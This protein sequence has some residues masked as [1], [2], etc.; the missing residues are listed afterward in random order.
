MKRRDFIAKGTAGAVGAGLAGCSSINVKRELSPHSFDKKVPKPSGT[1]PMGEIGTTGIKVS[2]FGFGSHMRKDIVPFEKDREWM[3]REAYDLGVRLFDV[4]DHE[5]ETYQYEPMGRHL[6]PFINDVAI[7]I[8]ILP[9]EGRTLE[10]EFERDLRLFGRDH[11][12]MVR[13]HSYN[14]NADNWYQ[15][16]HLFKWKEQGKIRAV[17]IPIHRIE[18]VEEPLATYPLD[19]VIFPFNFYHNWTWASY[20]MEQGKF[21]KYDS[22]IPRLREKGVGVISMKPMAG[23]N[24]AT[25]FRNLGAELDK[26]GEV[27]IAK[28]SL[29]YVINSNMNVDTT[30]CGMYY[31]YHVYDNVDAYFKPEL[32]SEEKTLLKKMR[33]KAKVVA[34][35]Y[36]Q[37]HYRFLED[38]APDSW[39]DTDLA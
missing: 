37:P 34:H 14:S 24:L 28:A 26:S 19:Y 29:R 20:E 1:M 7:S 25:P 27:N 23:D 18:D 39:N 4:Y 13:I 16:E 8:S 10:Q 9:W 30:V 33:R 36:L 15:W 31:P 38:W 5:Q 35:N 3:I 6:K 21:R 32:S 11:I 2:K 12:D 22:L 17:G